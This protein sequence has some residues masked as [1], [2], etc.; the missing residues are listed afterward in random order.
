L[1]DPEADQG[2]HHFAYSLLPHTGGWD[3]VTIPAAYGL[4]DRPIVWRKTDAKPELQDTARGTRDAAVSF[5][6]V[7]QPNIVIETVKQAE[8][9]DGVI[10]R[11]YESQRQRGTITLTT[12]FNLGKVWH[13]NLLEENQKALVPDGNS[14]KLFVKP[15]EIVT[16]RLLPA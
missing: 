3:K 11:L 2:E 5:V 8:N 13:T 16:L 7:D 9:G 15:Y 12:G 1:P 10:V 14:V 4:N 6:S